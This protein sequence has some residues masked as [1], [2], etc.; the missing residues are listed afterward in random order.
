MT[1]QR[2]TEFQMDEVSKEGGRWR[3]VGVDKDLGAALGFDLCSN[4]VSPSQS[5]G[6]T[7]RPGV[8]CLHSCAYLAFTQALQY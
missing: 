6:G 4:T 3:F 2:Q 7:L 1:A 5:A 8:Q